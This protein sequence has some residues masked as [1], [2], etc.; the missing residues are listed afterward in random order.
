M[1]KYKLGRICDVSSSKRIF[2]KEYVSSGVPF[3]RGK[4]IIQLKN[5]K[6]L[7][8]PLYIS[9][10]K[11]EEIKNKFGVPQ[12]GDILITSVGTIGESYQIKSSE[13]FYFKDGNVTRLS[14]FNLEEV[15]PKYLYYWINS[16]NFMK[17]VDNILIG[18][19]QK[20]LTIENLKNLEIDL[21]DLPTQNK[22]SNLL[23][24]LDDKIEINNKI[25]EELEELGQALY[26]KWF[27]NF[28]FP[29]E[30]GKPYKSSGGEM[31]ESEL[32]MIPKGWKVDNILNIFNFEKGVEPGSS[33][34]TNNKDDIRFIRVGDM[35]STSPDIY[36][37]KNIMEAKK[38]KYI[39]N[40]DITISLDGTIGKVFVG[41]EGCISSGIRIIKL[42]DYEDMIDYTYLFAKSKYLINSLTGG[43]FGSVIKHAGG[44]LN[45]LKIIHPNIEIL[46]EFQNLY[47]GIVEMIVQNRIENKKLEELRNFL[48]PQLMSGNLEV[49]DLEEKL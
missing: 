42:K 26:T 49:K 38:L 12:I 3:Y 31:I 16:S 41:N 9:H 27:V 33:N 34:Y 39:S 20:A 23:S 14:N 1:T 25:N 46:L 13:P 43:S 48:I 22:I 36:V 21:P 37:S 5:N 11:Y 35:Q 28:D 18:T 40:K 30:E 32:G 8:E 44:M 24:S 19:T 47:N 45:D 15:N 29:N 2:A 17:Q 6:P 4:E 7:S 10:E